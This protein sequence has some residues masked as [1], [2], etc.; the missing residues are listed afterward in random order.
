M[1][2][3][4]DCKGSGLRDTKCNFADDPQMQYVGNF[5]LRQLTA[6]TEK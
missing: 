4:H 2:I 3:T 6:L 5:G 1:V